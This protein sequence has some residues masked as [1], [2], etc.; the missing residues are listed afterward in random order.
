MSAIDQTDATGAVDT[1]YRFIRHAII[2]GELTPGESLREA[3]L[4]ERIGVSRTP[5]REALTR[6]SAE[7]LVV[8]ERYR[9]GHVAEFSLEDVAEVFRLRG[10]LEGHGARRAARRISEADLARLEDVEARLEAA[11]AEF[12]WHEHLALFDE[13]NNEFHGIIAAAAD[14]PRLDRILASSLELPASIFNRYSEPVEDRT[15]RTHVQHR[16]IIDAL[17]ARNPDW[18][19]AA[20]AGHLYSIIHLPGADD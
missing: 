11:F 8:L 20:M 12:G 19:E 6:L 17:K 9:R 3:R 18:A 13:L 15:R 7:G 10:K 16:Q 1:A 2:T 4:A 14:S 5:V